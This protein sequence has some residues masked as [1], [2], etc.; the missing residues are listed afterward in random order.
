VIRGNL[1][2]ADGIL[3]HTTVADLEINATMTENIGVFTNPVIG[4]D[5]VWTGFQNSLHF[6]GNQT[7]GLQ[8]NL[9][10]F[11]GMF[12]LSGDKSRDPELSQTPLFLDKVVNMS[13][14]AVKSWGYT[15]GSFNR[16]FLF[17]RS[18]VT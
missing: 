12:G 6:I 17:N 14:L 18:T 5:A 10:A 15:A 16:Q 9:S 13:Q 2:N 8:A 7:I 1:F 3:N 11:V 4:T